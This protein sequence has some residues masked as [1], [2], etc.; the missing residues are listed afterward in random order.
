MSRRGGLVIDAGFDFDLQIER[1]A[2]NRS[3][4]G[5]LAAL[6][7]NRPLFAQSLGA[8]RF[9]GVNITFGTLELGIPTGNILALRPIGATRH[10]AESDFSTEVHLGFSSPLPSCQALQ[11]RSR[12]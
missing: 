10:G 8:L 1:G 5:V 3:L 11:S 6:Q 12:R 9:L 4:R 2:L 7:A